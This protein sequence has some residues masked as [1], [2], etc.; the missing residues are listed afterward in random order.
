[1]KFLSCPY[2]TFGN[3]DGRPRRGVADGWLMGD[4]RKGNFACFLANRAY[5]KERK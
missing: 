4:P 2:F 1:M 3:F 5:T